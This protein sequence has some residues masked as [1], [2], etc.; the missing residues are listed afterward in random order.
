MGLQD[1]LEYQKTDAQLRQI[2]QKIGTSEERK[3]F[4]QAKKFVDA[5]LEKID[6]QDKRA[7][8]LAAMRDELEARCAEFTKQI[9]EYSDLEEM[10]EGG[11][12]LGFYKKNALALLERIRSVKAELNKIV[13]E[14]NAMFE[15]FKALR[16][17][18][19]IKQAEKEKYKG[20]LD[21]LKAQYA[22]EV[23]EIQ[24]RL[25]ALASKFKPEILEKYKAKR[26]EGIFPIFVPLTD[27]R[28][29]CGMDLSLA[30]Q[31][32]LSGGGVIECEH[33]RR[34]IYNK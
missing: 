10:V 16:D 19:G 30:Q 23:K 31:G 14:S 26:K 28:C 7:A 1:L 24:A 17:Q 33:C 15:E 5:A 8:E 12:D 18:V 34:F 21:K 9:E 3:K 13:A 11:G 20:D 22:G 25:D 6:S 2:E 4:I 29:M 27:G 32:K